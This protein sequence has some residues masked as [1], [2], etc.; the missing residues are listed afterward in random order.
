MSLDHFKKRHHTSPARLP[1]EVARGLDAEAVAH[2][3]GLQIHRQGRHVELANGMRGTD[4]GGRM[5]WCHRDGTGIGDNLALVQA[6]LGLRFK[7]ALEC[8]A[9]QAAMPVTPRV[10]APPRRL[11]LPR[12]AEA[13][14]IAG[15]AYLYSRH[16][17]P[18]ALDTAEACGML[19]YIPG[20]V[21][22]VGYDGDQPRSAT[23][24]GYLSADP[25]PKR[26]LAGSDKA[27]PPILPGCPETV[28]VVEGGA[29][30]L[31]L[32]TLY[33]DNPPTVI[34]SGGS[35]C[36]AWIEQSHI[37]ILLAA[38]FSVIVARDRESNAETQARTDAQHLRQ[39][40][41]LRALTDDVRLW[42]PPPGIKDL[43]DL[44]KREAG[45]VAH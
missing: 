44:L 2:H 37:Q 26:D 12:G 36:M 8:L 23:R 38:A 9:G 31:A 4:K 28:W 43:A 29:D 20:A 40:D 41:W 21:L 19:R 18:S 32:H 17:A 7:P 5:V 45:H 25:V 16:I 14:R 30:A 1:V 42:L 27:Y 24:R 34:V 22:F 11:R 39:V 35:G 13:D 10:S 3:L 33:P 15:R 6:V